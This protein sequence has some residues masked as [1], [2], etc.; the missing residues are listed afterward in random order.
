MQ[1]LGFFLVFVAFVAGLFGLV[2]H[3][4][5]KKILSAPFK[6]TGEIAANP[7]VA[8]AKGIVSCE[9]AVQPLQQ[10][11]APCSGQPCLYYEVEIIREWEKTVST[12]DGVKTEKGK[13][14]L[15]TVKS[16]PVFAVND[17]SGPVYVNP[18]GGMDVELDKSFEQSQ[19]VAYGTVIFGNFRTEVSAPGG[20]KY[21]RGVKAIEKIVPPGGN[22]FVMG[23]L[24]NGQIIKPKGMLGTLRASRK[25]RDHMIGAAKRNKTIGLVAAGVMMLPGVGLSIFADPP[26]PVAAGDNACNILDESK[27]G[28]ACTGKITSDDGSD[29]KLTVTQAGTFVIHGSAPK[30]KKIPLIAE[31]SV[32]DAAGKMFATNEHEEAEVDL[33]PGDYTITVKDGVKGASAKFKGGFSFE[34]TVKRTALKDGPGAVASGGPAAVDTA[35][36][37]TGA[38]VPAGMKPTVK[39]GAAIVKPAVATAAA[40]KP[41]ATAAAASAKPATSAAPAATGAAAKAPA[42]AAPAAAPPAASAKK[43]N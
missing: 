29:V 28:Q 13:D 10:F 38:A 20:D 19:N 14:S 27:A 43:P 23:Q 40:L 3:L 6:R 15:Q 21:S 4:K 30:G 24:D 12:E 36:T 16:G 22:L 32:K 37:T 7:G 31:I 2:Q 26:A 8:D 11:V 17:G 5:G 34:L 41:A 42:A 18:D 39:A 25:G 33:V 35:T 9:G 1:Y